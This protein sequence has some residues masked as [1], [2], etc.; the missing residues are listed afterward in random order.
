[1]KGKKS[2]V[3]VPDGVLWELPFQALTPAPGRF[4][5]EDHTI[6]YAPSLTVLRELAKRKASL[7]KTSS[8]LLAFGNPTLS[9]ELSANW[10]ALPN[11]EKQVRQLGTLFGATASKIYLNADASEQRFKAEAAHYGI[12]NL[13]THGIFDNQTPMASRLLLAASQQ[14]DGALEA[15]EIMRLKL[16]AQLVVLSACE[17]ARGYI[18]PGEGLIGLT[19]AFL[20]AGA[21]TVIVSQWQVR[22][23]A[24]AELMQSFYQRLNT[25]T[26]KATRAEALRQAALAVRKAYPHPFYWAGFVLMGNGN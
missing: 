10:P 1:L 26:T 6:A 23:D 24:T 13:A 19:W 12:L 2:L 18:G 17:T 3:I 22:E 25:S 8:S 20:Q 15:H 7:T 4:L 14:D 5:L 21:P 11:A 9:A 16:Q